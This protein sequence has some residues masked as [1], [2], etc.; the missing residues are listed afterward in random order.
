MLYEEKNT[1]RTN[2][3]S[4]CVS[5]VLVLNILILLFVFI[6]FNTCEKKKRFDIAF[7]ITA[8][9]VQ[10]NVCWFA[11]C[12]ELHVLGRRHGEYS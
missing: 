6:A 9:I 10:A 12:M 5:L 1:Q 11:L 2:L 8:I 7:I 4:K 3:N